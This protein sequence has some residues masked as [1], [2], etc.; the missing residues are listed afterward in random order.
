[1][2]RLIRFVV[3]LHPKVDRAEITSTLQDTLAEQGRASAARELA[4]LAA[5]GLR[6]RTG[7]TAASPAG[8]LLASVAPLATASAVALSSLF[9]L[10][11]E[12]DWKP[13]PYGRNPS[14]DHL[15]PFD[16]LGPIAYFM[17]LLVSLAALRGRGGAVR[18]LAAVAVVATLVIVPL[19]SFTGVDR[20]PL[21]LLS[22]LSLFGVIVLAAPVDPLR[23][24]TRD[25][26][27]L[28]TGTAA[29][30]LIL[31]IFVLGYGEAFSGA[32]RPL[33][34]RDGSTGPMGV[35]VE[36]SL[37]VALVA[38]VLCLRLNRRLPLTVAVVG[39]P[40]VVFALG[41]GARPGSFTAAVLSGAG[42]IALG[43]V[44]GAITLAHHVGRRRTIQPNDT[45]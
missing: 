40:W 19:A 30:F 17:W 26:R 11:A 2:T 13:N 39:L 9:L 23:R 18:L 42:L 32:A 35:M 16:T 27:T 43:L 29:V 21:Y 5:H 10:F 38:S 44:T 45:D 7:L 3:R 36:C 41:T 34:Y 20:P 6:Q 28:A 4:D 15:G 25:R 24:P 22:A 31:T 12:W 8:A 37:V 33:W 1:M 14:V